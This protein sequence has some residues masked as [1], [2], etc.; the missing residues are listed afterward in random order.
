MTEE[1]WAAG[2]EPMNLLY[3]W[4]LSSGS[5]L[6]KLRLLAVACCQRK[7]KY[8]ADA[9]CQRV[10][11]VA[12]QYADDEHCIGDLDLARQQCQLALGEWRAKQ[13]YRGQMVRLLTALHG[14]ASREFYLKTILMDLERVPID[15][16]RGR[17][18]E[19]AKQAVLV[20]EVFGN[21]SSPVT[22]DPRWQSETVVALAGGIYTDRAFDRMPI[23][24]DAL[25]EAGCDNADILTHCRGDGPH[26][27]ECWV[28]DLL[29]GKS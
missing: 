4:T 7:A 10:I 15:S 20:R 3:H 11:K 17:V 6:R 26:V 5:D 27:R 29:L 16:Q 8:F 1:E 2:V 28:V 18:E 21:L 24:A 14:T 9:R 13:G 12:E 25:E 23:L 22:L 19:A